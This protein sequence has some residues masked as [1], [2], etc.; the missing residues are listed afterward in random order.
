MLS[1]GQENSSYS[2][3]EDSIPALG[4]GAHPPGRLCSPFLEVLHPCDRR[5]APY[6][7]GQHYFTPARVRQL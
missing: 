3:Q 5:E 6:F 2:G 1:H 7:C 4:P